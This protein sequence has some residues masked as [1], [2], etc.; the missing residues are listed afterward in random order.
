MYYLFIYLCLKLNPHTTAD[1]QNPKFPQ[2]INAYPTFYGTLMFITLF[3]RA[4]YL[5]LSC[6]G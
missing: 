6:A 5:S 3:N 2:L 1:L 4:H